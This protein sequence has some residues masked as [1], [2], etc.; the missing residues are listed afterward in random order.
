[1][2]LLIVNKYVFI[3]TFMK[4]TLVHQGGYT[5]VCCFRDKTTAFY[6]SDGTVGG[7]SLLVGGRN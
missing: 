7:R 1:M 6:R 4:S 5:V 3:L 2:D